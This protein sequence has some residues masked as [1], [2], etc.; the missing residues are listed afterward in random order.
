MIF[1]CFT[2]GAFV[3]PIKTI[4]FVKNAIMEL[5]ENANTD[6]TYADEYENIA[7]VEIEKNMASKNHARL[8]SRLATVLNNSY[9][10]DF[11]VFTEFE[12]ELV[13][14]RV[15]PDLSIF[16]IEIPDWDN[17]VIRGKDIP[18]L[19]IEIL[20]PKQAFDEIV[21]KIREIYFPAGVRSSWMIL[22]KT[23]MV[24]VFTPDGNV[25][26]YKKEY[27]KDLASG[28]HVD[29]GEIFK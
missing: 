11:E 23:R 4:I 15:I 1:A 18:I 28:F 22:P 27:V 6:L 12:L 24:M 3:I 17:D 7:E 13:G 8:Q 16:P 14:K 10:K 9:D 21:T 5:I 26:T 19:A 29:F 2:E 20:S 25:N